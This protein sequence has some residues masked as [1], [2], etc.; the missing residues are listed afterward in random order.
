MEWAER[1]DSD[2]WRSYIITDP[3]ATDSKGGRIEFWETEGLLVMSGAP[4]W[5]LNDGESPLSEGASRRFT[6]AIEKHDG[7]NPVVYQA[8]KSTMRYTALLRNLKKAHPPRMTKLQ[9][10]MANAT[11]A[12]ASPKGAQIR[13]PTV[14][15]S[16]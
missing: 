1:P 8:L 13:T 9:T 2:T 5:E 3:P 14:L 16:L 7:I 4:F 12:P 6:R 11:S 10:A 15:L